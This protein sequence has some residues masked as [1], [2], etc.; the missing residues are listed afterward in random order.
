MII[1]NYQRVYEQIIQMVHPF[2][3]ALIELEKVF[4]MLSTWKNLEQKAIL[5]VEDYKENEVVHNRHSLLNV[6]TT[7]FC[8][9]EALG[10]CS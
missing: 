2:K 9:S 1:T 6:M 3:K 7:Q 10:N 4:I 8:S 5:T